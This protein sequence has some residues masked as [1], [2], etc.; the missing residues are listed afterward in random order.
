LDIGVF[1]VRKL[2]DFLDQCKTAPRPIS[3]QELAGLEAAAAILTDL[4]KQA[5][6][7]A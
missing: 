3:E 1:D 6:R 4:V 2:S 7:S 5:K